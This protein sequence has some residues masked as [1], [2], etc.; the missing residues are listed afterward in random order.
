MPCG[1]SRPHSSPQLGMGWSRATP[2]RRQVADRTGT[3]YEGHTDG[4]GPPASPRVHAGEAAVRGFVRCK[5]LSEGSFEDTP[6]LMAA[7]RQGLTR[8]ALPSIGS[9]RRPIIGEKSAA[10]RAGRRRRPARRWPGREAQ[11]ED[12]DPAPRGEEEHHRHRDG[13]PDQLGDSRRALRVRAPDASEARPRTPWPDRPARESE[14][15]PAPRAAPSSRRS[16]P[17]DAT[18]GSAA[19]RAPSPPRSPRLPCE[20]DRPTS[21]PAYDLDHRRVAR[22]RI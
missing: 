16:P 12:D 20:H 15:A 4:R 10:K 7:F 17:P 11:I 19:A 9:S 3:I 13:D 14:R 6:D 5:C 22:T 18:P 1:S 21:G 8:Q 2:C